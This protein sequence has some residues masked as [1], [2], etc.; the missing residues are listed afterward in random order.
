MNKFNLNV[1]YNRKINILKLRML[2][3]N[4]I[5]NFNSNL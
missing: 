1:Q 2:T 3:A 4:Q 5:Y